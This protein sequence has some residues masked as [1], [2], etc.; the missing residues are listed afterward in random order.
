M[1]APGPLAPLAL[2]FLLA[3]F[4]A[5]CGRKA[6]DTVLMTVADLVRD[7]RT[8]SPVLVLRAERGGE[9]LRLWIGVA[10]A[11]AIAMEM[12][13][14]AAPRPMTHDLLRDALAKA[15]AEVE[16]VEI[17]E[18]R[19]ATFLAEIAL[20]VRGDRVTVDAR[21]SDAVALAL[22]AKA[23]IRARR[24]VIARA[25]RATGVREARA[26]RGLGASVQTLAGALAEATDHRTGDGVLVSAV[27]AGSLAEAMGLRRGDVV[28]RVGGRKVH[29]AGEFALRARAALEAHGVALTVDR[30]GARLRL[31]ADVE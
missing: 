27:E 18:L 15:G 23:P 29:C 1:R 12:E 20:R 28:T 25:A 5:G 19:E 9:P 10:E 24:E 11:R 22:R 17:T 21:P 7:P 13:G 2:S 4:A 6:P 16:S 8:D 14:V 31:A 3:S 26:D 30:A